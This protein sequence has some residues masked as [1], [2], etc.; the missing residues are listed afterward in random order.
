VELDLEDG[1]E[2]EEA[3]A[4]MAAVGSADGALSKS[5]A[6]RLFALRGAEMTA[7]A[8]AAARATAD[9]T[10]EL[11]RTA[12]LE[13]Q[14]TVA[15]RALA[16]EEARLAAACA[17][18]EAAEAEAASAGA[19][20]ASAAEHIAR[21]TR[22]GLALD[23]AASQAAGA[24]AVA[25]ATSKILASLRAAAEAKAEEAAFKARC[26]KELAALQQ[27]AGEEGVPAEEAAWLVQV[28][29]AHAADA[30]RL[31]ALRATA[32][33]AALGCAALQRRLA[34]RP[35][36]PELAIYE[37]RFVELADAIA[38]KLAA[39][40]R[41]YAAYNATAEALRLAQAE[42]TLLNQVR[43]QFI[44]ASMSGPEAVDAFAAQLSTVAAGVAEKAARAKERATREQAALAAVTS[45]CAA[46]REL[47][48]QHFAAVQRLQEACAQSVALQKK[49]EG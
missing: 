40:K 43:E 30:A 47:E 21:C 3:A 49:L 45:E 6:Q 17:A 25:S 12:A 15:A 11:A 9:P 42:T 24:E 13:R 7:A 18:A 14:R 33:R 32:G 38:A 37:R 10:G 8:A 2:E 35:G 1:E 19:D 48:R 28:A 31:A 34:E 44:A 39:T 16:V 27:T 36:R 29:E 23:E 41:G 4:A 22:E 5:V 46:R 20:H 26:R